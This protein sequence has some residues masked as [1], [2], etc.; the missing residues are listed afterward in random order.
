MRSQVGLKAAGTLV[1]V[2]IQHHCCVHADA[3]LWWLQAGGWVT[4]ADL[5]E[6]GRARC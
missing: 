4:T 6:V 3:D 2:M 1:H 5:A